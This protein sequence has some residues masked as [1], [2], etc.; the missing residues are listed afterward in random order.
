MKRVDQRQTI[1]KAAKQRYGRRNKPAGRK[2]DARKKR[3]FCFIAESDR[4]REGP[5]SSNPN[6]IISLPYRPG[7]PGGPDLFKTGGKG[8]HSL[9]GEAAKGARRPLRHRAGPPRQR[10]ASRTTQPRETS[11]IFRI[12]SSS[13][14]RLPSARRIDAEPRF[15]GGLYGFARIQIHHPRKIF[16]FYAHFPRA[17]S[18]TRREPDPVRALEDWSYADVRG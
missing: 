14:F 16:R 1:D 4:S 5:S 6:W 10:K 13:S 17:I 11:T 12:P 18:I 15:H 3:G 7:Y 9:D 2:D 8:A